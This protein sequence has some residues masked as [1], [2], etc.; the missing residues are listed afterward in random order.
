MAEPDCSIV[1]SHGKSG[2]L[3]LAVIS[4]AADYL[5][6]PA[7]SDVGNSRSAVQEIGRKTA[8]VWKQFP[9]SDGVV[10]SAFSWKKLNL[11]YATIKCGE[12]WRGGGVG[13]GGGGG[14]GGIL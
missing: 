3:T 6:Q 10:Q 8:V 12:G 13:V 4:N 11:T 7:L 1:V 14:G 5:S 2:N 9:V